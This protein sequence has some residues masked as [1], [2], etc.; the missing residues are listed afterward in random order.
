MIRNGDAVWI[1]R[2]SGEWQEATLGRL[3]PDEFAIQVIWPHDKKYGKFQHKSVNVVDLLR[4]QKEAEKQMG[5]EA[6]IIGLVEETSDKVSKVI[7]GKKKEKSLKKQT[8]MEHEESYR[9]L[10]LLDSEDCWRLYNTDVRVAGEDTSVTFDFQGYVRETRPEMINYGTYYHDVMATNGILK[11]EGHN[12]VH[13]GT[14]GITNYSDYAG[15]HKME[16]PNEVGEY[17]IYITIPGDLQ[18]QTSCV[19]DYDSCYSVSEYTEKFNTDQKEIDRLQNSKGFIVIRLRIEPKEDPLAREKVLTIHQAIV[20][21]IENKKPLHQI[22]D[23]VHRL[24]EELMDL[25]EDEL[26]RRI[27]ELAQEPKGLIA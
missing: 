11:A 14:D 10:P 21:W 19:C 15:M 20:K 23:M 6:K 25:D 24:E 26:K 3:H 22:K 16:S 13:V 27:K 4:W 17:D 5:S 8:A 18:K 7:S 9:G 12:G 2:T 1:K